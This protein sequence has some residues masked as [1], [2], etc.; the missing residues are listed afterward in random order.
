MCIL[1]TL[2][3]SDN[4][5]CL[6]R[7]E[8][9]LTELT[10][11]MTKLPQTVLG[12]HEV[13]INSVDS[14]NQLMIAIHSLKMTA[15]EED[16]NDDTIELKIELKT[17]ETEGI[18]NLV[19]DVKNE[20]TICPYCGESFKNR[21]KFNKHMERHE[22]G[23]KR[24]QCPEP[25]CEE[26]FYIEYDLQLHQKK[27]QDKEKIFQC[28]QC[29]YRT[30]VK[31]YL[32]RHIATHSDARP[33]VC[34][35]CGRGFKDPSSLRKHTKIHSGVKDHECELCG[36]AFYERR[37]LKEHMKTHTGESTS[38]KRKRQEDQVKLNLTSPYF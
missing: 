24:L 10:F 6:T 28:D 18:A 8:K 26:T 25:D 22:A 12:S 11:E 9:L 2:H 1:Y 15:T 3:F 37:D 4:M 33:H 7:M 27:H 34:S 35:E 38:R 23:E 31:Y 5:E 13:F 32:D 17:V 20:S 21:W 36:K 29:E 16:L 30:H 19:T 14:L